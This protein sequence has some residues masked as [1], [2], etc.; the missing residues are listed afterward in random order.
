[1]SALG[2]GIIAA[3]AWGIHDACVRYIS[4]QI[5]IFTA[6][7]LVLVSGT[8]LLVPI[9]LVLGEGSLPSP[10][11]ILFSIAS[12][13]AFAGAGIG[14]YKAFSYGPVSLVAPIIGAYP[15][16]SMFW[17]VYSGTPVSILQWLAVIGIIAGIAIV[18][19]PSENEDTPVVPKSTVILWALFANVAWASTFIFGQR[20]TQTDNA[21][22]VLLFTRIIS[23]AT[24]VPVV[25]LTGSSFKTSLQN[26]PLLCL[27][28]AL[29]AIALG[30]A[31]YAGGLE[32]PE[33]AAVATSTFG[34]VTILLAWLFLREKMSP[35]QWGGVAIVFAGIGYLAL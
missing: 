25:V 35:Q 13:I 4:Q 5:N 7:F 16:I 6:L 27:L 2:F 23:I 26:L 17:A 12:G 21:F 28:G 19:S 10:D 1:M 29:D 9:T 34:V 22:D 14:L 30:C 3:L 15:V 24:V 33:Y 11:A 20:A 8:V 31:L 32:N 18:A